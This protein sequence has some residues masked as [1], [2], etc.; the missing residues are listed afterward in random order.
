[1][2]TRSDNGEDINWSDATKYAEQLRLGGYSD[3]RL[4][5][6][7]E[8]EKLYDANRGSS[9]CIRKPFRLTS[10]WVWSSTKEGLDS[11]WLFYFGRGKR[12]SAHMD[13]SNNS[14]ALCVRRS[15]E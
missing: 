1:M 5:T 6:I 11:A 2:W 10:Y 12:Y 14:R 8:L 7:D 4:P 9:Y 3:W 15:G 13:G